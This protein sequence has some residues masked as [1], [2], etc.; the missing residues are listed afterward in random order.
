MKCDI[1]LFM[2]A[3]A[4]SV[5]LVGL[6]GCI[7]AAGRTVHHRASAPPPEVVHTTKTTVIKHSGPTTYV[8]KHQF[9]YYPDA[10]VYRDCESNRWHWVENN[11]WKVSIDLPRTIVLDND[12]P[13]AIEL[14][15]DEPAI[16]HARI[17][18]ENPGRKRGHDQD[19]DWGGD[20]DRDKDR[21]GRG[22]DKDD[23][24]RKGRHGSGRTRS[25]NGSR[26]D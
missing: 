24:D 23:D 26:D 25:A 19:N 14:E 6:S 10:Q 17:C 5:C 12:G 9:Y 22:K 3:A 16:H 20:G 18:R 7:F 2:G 15:G 1:R 21:Y 8:R 13:L 4:M 11:S